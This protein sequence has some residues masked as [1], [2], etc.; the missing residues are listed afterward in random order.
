MP[1]KELTEQ[2]SL[3]IIQQMINR[4][5]NEFVDTGIG[6]ILWGA[7]I[8]FCSIVQY[9]QLEFN[10]KLPVDI[11]LLTIAAL[12]PQIIISIKERKKRKAKGWDSDVMSYV[13]LC[14]GIGVFIVSFINNVASEQLNTFLTDYEEITGK[15][16][17]PHFMTFGTSYLMFL[18][19]YPTIV[20]GASRNF[21]LMTIGG[22][23]CW[24]AALIS[25]FTVIKFDFLLMAA[26]ATLAWLIPGIVL[27][28]KYLL[29]ID[30]NNV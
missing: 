1:E 25:V 30:E 17:V 26:S 10:F 9:L 21:K 14:F 11:W 19:G 5:K 16:D 22:I 7:V 12:V 15:P 28:K 8:T 20:T 4:A 2:E 29:H 13:W 27:R 3:L 18:Y 24:V 23:F 6:P